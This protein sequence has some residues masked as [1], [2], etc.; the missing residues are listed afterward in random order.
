MCVHGEVQGVFY[1]DSVRR[2]AVDR[3]VSGS[4]RNCEDGSVEVVLEGSR[5][6]VEALIAYCAD[7][8]ERARVS[9][10]EVSEEEPEGVSGFQTA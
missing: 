8:P 5:E 6:A 10:V 3:G 2:L 4:A 7:G 1:R 9:R